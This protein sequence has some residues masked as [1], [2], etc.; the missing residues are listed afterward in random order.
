M[1]TII[2]LIIIILTL[3]L[4]FKA[5]SDISRT[6]FKSDSNNRTWFFIVF[7]IPIFGAIIYFMLKKKYILTKTS[8]QPRG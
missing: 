5:I 8:Y 7:F 3:I 4:W 6:K 1:K 2:I